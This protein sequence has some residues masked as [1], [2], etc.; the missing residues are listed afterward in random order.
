[1]SAPCT[2][3]APPR[4]ACVSSSTIC[5]PHPAPATPPQPQ[6]AHAHQRGAQWVRLCSPLSTPRASCVPASVPEPGTRWG[7][8]AAGL[9]L[10]QGDPSVREH[11]GDSSLAAS[12]LARSHAVF[13]SHACSLVYCPLL[14]QAG[15][16]SAEP[17]VLS[18]L[19]QGTSQLPGFLN[20]QW[21]HWFSL[22][23]VS[24]CIV[25]SARRSRKEEG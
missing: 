19:N 5:C 21:S 9:I 2:T 12:R 1:M 23:R 20:G 7:P 11:T 14:H 3:A 10:V 24:V 13:A 18:T 8:D 17:V 6:G 25:Q 22:D 16:M 15:S 4:G